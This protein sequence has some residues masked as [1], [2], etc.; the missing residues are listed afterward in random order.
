M[1]LTAV[2]EESGVKSPKYRINGEE[3]MEYTEA[4]QFNE[5][6]IFTLEYHSS[7]NSGNVE[8]VKSIKIKLDKTAPETTVAV[9]PENPT[10]TTAGIL[11]M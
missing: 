8:E 2:D 3:W 10:G 9:N 11:L 5:D 7:D 4:I 6:G 1:T